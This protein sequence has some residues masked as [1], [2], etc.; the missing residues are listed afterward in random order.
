MNPRGRDPDWEPDPYEAP[1]ALSE[2]LGP[3]AIGRG[4]PKNLLSVTHDLT[5]DELRRFVN[6]DVYHDPM[7]LLGLIPQWVLLASFAGAAGAV[8]GLG[9]VNTN[10][11]IIFGVLT[12]PVLFLGI[13]DL[14]AA[15]RR[16]HAQALGL[17]EERTVTVSPR[18]L[19]VQIPAARTT[20]MIAIGPAMRSWS[21]IRLVSISEDDLTFW[22]R[23]SFRDPEGR[24]RMIVPLRTFAKPAEAAA[25][26]NAARR[27]HAVATGGDAT[28]WDE[29][30]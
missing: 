26:E 3:Q 14:M 25:F 18:G 27:W 19:S 30:N 11:A 22:M 13:L 4:H 28:W 17:C 24:A 1:W 15:S 7:P 29:P 6:F 21:D 16:R 9:T 2:P 20:S 12:F 5:D 23:R 10:P 8:A